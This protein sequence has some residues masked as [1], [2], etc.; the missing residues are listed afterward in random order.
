MKKCILA[1]FFIVV[2]IINSNAQYIVD[3]ESWCPPGA[4]WIY[5]SF[6]PTCQLYYMFSYE[7]DTLFFNRS[8]KKINVSEVKYF[9]ERTI[10]KVG[11]EFLYESNDSI[12]WFDK[13]NETFEF[14]YSFNVQVNDTLILK[15]SRATCL[16]DTTYPKADTV[17]VTQVFDDTIG[18]RIFKLYDTSTDKHFQLGRVI[19]KIGAY[20]APFPI[21]N[22]DLCESRNTLCVGCVDYTLVSAEYGEFYETYAPQCYKDDIRGTLPISYTNE[23]VCYEL[24]TSVKEKNSEQVNYYFKIFPNPSNSEIQIET[25]IKAVSFQV[26][27]M[28]GR[29]IMSN[30]AV[31]N[32]V[33]I[34]SFS[35]GTYIIHLIDAKGRKYSKRFIKH[36]L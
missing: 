23:E 5:K 26:F 6:C 24:F 30:D 2:S 1:C 8:A 14:L 18:N 29:I 25:S 19:N 11:E 35:N 28:Y 22:Q 17:I 15:N 27:D 12:Y 3:N 32:V 31:N 7:K 4:T 9:F 33:D 20:G 16:V 36:S 10:T 13:V 21:I 34:S